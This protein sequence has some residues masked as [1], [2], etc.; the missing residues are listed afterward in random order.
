MAQY[1]CAALVAAGIGLNIQNAT[2][3]YGISENRLALMAVGGSNSVT[4]TIWDSFTNWVSSLWNGSTNPDSTN[5]KPDNTPK[6]YG[7]KPTTVTNHDT[8]TGSTS[9]GG[10]AKVGYGPVEGEGH[11]EGSTSTSHQETYNT[12]KYKCTT[13]D[14]A[15]AAYST[16]EECKKAGCE[17]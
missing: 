5:P 9:G 4:G 15:D 13:V 7:C 10:K 14:G 2:V 3:N 1:C 16:I 12:S 8:T 11:V 6:R 17:D